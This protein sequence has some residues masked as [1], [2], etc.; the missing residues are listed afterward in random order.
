MA[1]YIQVILDLRRKK[2]DDTYPI[3]FR[4]I[5]NRV[6]TTINTGYSIEKK[7]WDEKKSSVKR[8]C[9]NIP[10]VVGLNFILK[11]KETKL[12]EKIMELDGKGIL[13][14]MAIKDLKKELGQVTVNHGQNNSFVNFGK[15]VIDELK[16]EKRYGSASAYQDAMRF[17][18]NYSGKTDI[19]YSE[20]N[21]TFLKLLEKRY[22]AKP[23]NHYN[24]MAAYL[25]AIR[26]IYNKAIAKGYAQEYQYPF[27]RTTLDKLKYHIRTEKTKKRAVSKDI[28]RQIEAFDNGNESLK[29]YKFYFLFSFY[30]MGMNMVDL[31]QLQKRNINNNIL[32]YKRA[33]T[34]KTYEIHLNEKTWE[35]LQ[36]FDFAAKK[37]NDLLFPIIKTPG[38]G[39]SIQKQIKNAIKHT[40]KA[41]GVIA[42]DLG[43]EVKLTT[44]VSRHTWATI[45]DKAGIDR[46]II[47]KG[48]GHSNLHTTE[49]YINDIVSNDDLTD[50]NDLITG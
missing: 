21:A 43:L 19:S 16:K 50:A 15:S 36:Y 29:K 41:L 18:V 5:H 38:D 48:L 4:L 10:D 46:R 6:P 17:L 47:S 28:I 32:I 44:Y 26:A 24:G 33:K 1:T 39:A 45:A 23:N 40:N 2:S 37:K 25:R 13:Q 8:G 30:T 49:I 34:G 42:S 20:L 9:K 14:S 27:R 7:Y 22:I 35:I 31:A 3:S 12:L 11:R